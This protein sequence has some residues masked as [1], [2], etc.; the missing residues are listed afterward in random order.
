VALDET[1]DV[2]ARQADGN[3]LDGMGQEGDS[4]ADGRHDGDAV[5]RHRGRQRRTAVPTR[6]AA[7]SGPAAVPHGP[8]R[9][10]R[11]FHHPPTVAKEC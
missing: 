3:H 1:G 11:L 6:P 8:G 2:E 9:P 4:T 5:L 10:D 7:V